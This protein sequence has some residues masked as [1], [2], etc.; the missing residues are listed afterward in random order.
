[1]R[2]HGVHRA[3]A[4]TGTAHGPR[5]RSRPRPDRTASRPVADTGDRTAATRPPTR[6]RPLGLA[7]GQATGAAVQ[8]NV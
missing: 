8:I 1:M 2:P 3:D 6:G 5:E 7:A 4:P